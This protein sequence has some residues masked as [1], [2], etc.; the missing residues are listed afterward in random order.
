MLLKASLQSTLIFVFLLALAACSK[1][2]MFLK[3]RY[4]Q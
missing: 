2:I 1:G 4:T 3:G